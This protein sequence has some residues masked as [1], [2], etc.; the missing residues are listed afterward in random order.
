[1]MKDKW[2]MFTLKAEAESDARVGAVT[3][4]QHPWQGFLK[5]ALSRMTAAVKL[6]V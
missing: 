2:W 3:A 5:C 6:R 1:M 4:L